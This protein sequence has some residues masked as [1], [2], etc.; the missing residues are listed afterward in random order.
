MQRINGKPGMRG[1]WL[2]MSAVCVT[3][4]LALLREHKTSSNEHVSCIW[5]W[6]EAENTQKVG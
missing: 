4:G 6:V 5:R 3:V 2:K 1:V